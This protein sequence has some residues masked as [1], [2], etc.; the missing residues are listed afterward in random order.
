MAIYTKHGKKL[1]NTRIRI[2]GDCYVGD[3]VIK[4]RVLVEGEGVPRLLYVTDLLADNGKEEI[5][6][7]IKAALKTR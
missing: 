5:E 1:D 6:A 7:V 4:I 2:D 3:K